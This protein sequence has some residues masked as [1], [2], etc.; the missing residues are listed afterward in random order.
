[1]K[2]WC[3]DDVVDSPVDEVESGVE[4]GKSGVMDDTIRL[5]KAI[6]AGLLAQDILD[7]GCDYPN[8]T[9]EELAILAQEGRDARRQLIEGNIGL[10]VTIACDFVRSRRM[11]FDD[12][13]QEGCVGLYEAVMRY[14]WRKGPFGPYA[15]LWIR[16]RIRSAMPTTTTFPLVDDVEDT[17]WPLQLSRINE[18]EG[19]GRVLELVPTQ[20]RKVVDLRT[21]WSGA[22]HSQAQVGKV[23]NLSLRRVKQLESEALAFMREQW[24]LSE[25]A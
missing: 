17:S 5:A 10:V 1:M 15:G 6:E 23:M 21:G 13:Y 8:A 3:P 20:A 9:N 25:A 12:L 2:K 24:E 19:L 18:Q 14:D 4:E 16:A 11:S 22:S 7:S